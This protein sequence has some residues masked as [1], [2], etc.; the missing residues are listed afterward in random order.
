[1]NYNKNHQTEK[2][3]KCSKCNTWKNKRI[4]FYLYSSGYYDSY[5]F[6]CKANL[7][8]I[9]RYGSLEMFKTEICL[10]K[11]KKRLH[12]KYLSQKEGTHFRCR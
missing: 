2:R 1:M 10:P 7:M 12:K 8:R 4:S 9:K 5:C 6:E 3:R 11:L